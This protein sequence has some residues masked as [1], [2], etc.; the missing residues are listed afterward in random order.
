[1]YSGYGSR[2]TNGGTGLYD[3]RT[4]QLAGK[5]N[6]ALGDQVRA[7]RSARAFSEPTSTR[8]TAATRPSAA[9]GYT[10]SLG[11]EY[12]LDLI[13]T[14]LGIYMDWTRNSADLSTTDP[15]TTAANIGDQTASM[16]TL[17]VNV[18]L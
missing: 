7:V 8:A 4:L 14:G 11:V 13:A 2:S 5:Y 12:R 9:T 1:M 17:G 15:T 18:S 16:W 6:L 3:S 10:M